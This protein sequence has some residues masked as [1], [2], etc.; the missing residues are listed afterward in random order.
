MNMQHVRVVLSY[1][2]EQIKS[3]KYEIFDLLLFFYNLSVNEHLTT[4]RKYE[5]KMKFISVNDAVMQPEEQKRFSFS[6]CSIHVIESVYVSLCL[7]FGC[8]CWR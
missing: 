5:K 3:T 7:Y 2:C 6:I 4:N 8:K 1:I